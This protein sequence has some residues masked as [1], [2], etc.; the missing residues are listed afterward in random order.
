MFEK[1]YMA[2]II[3]LVVITFISTYYLF[4]VLNTTLSITSYTK[5]ENNLVHIESLNERI[6]TLSDSLTT[7]NE[8]QQLIIR[9]MECLRKEIK[10][11]D[12]KVKAYTNEE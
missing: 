8:N 4:T 11:I 3:S 12:Y 7:L 1:G 6:N 9:S 2:F 5:S 10:I